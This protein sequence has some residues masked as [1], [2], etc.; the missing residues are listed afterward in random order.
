MNVMILG[1]GSTIGTLGRITFA[2]ELG[3]NGFTK[4]LSRVKPE[5]RQKLPHL[6]SAIDE[7]GFD[8]LDQIWTH[9]D[10]RGK[11]ARSLRPLKIEP[12][13]GDTSGEL[14]KALVAAYS[15]TSE[16]EQVDLDST[17]TLKTA[18]M[19]LG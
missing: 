15:L 14:H 4:R 1:T 16:V 9:I 6:A 13:H 10:Y 2:P 11:L 12:Y 18:L 3:V 5:W 7:S 19:G 17:F 8:N